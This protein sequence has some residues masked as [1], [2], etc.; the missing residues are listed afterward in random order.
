MNYSVCV[1]GDE[2]TCQPVQQCVFMAQMKRSYQA[3]GLKVNSSSQTSLNRFQQFLSSK[4]GREWIH[5]PEIIW[6]AASTSA[7]PQTRAPYFLLSHSPSS[8]RTVCG[9]LGLNAGALPPG[10]CVTAAAGE[11]PQQCSMWCSS[12]RQ[13]WSDTAAAPCRRQ[14]TFTGR[15]HLIPKVFA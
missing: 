13:S 2:G 5:R 11:S 3:V 10:L 4:H 12:C 7:F 14:P 8:H 6:S 15:T 1:H 9:G